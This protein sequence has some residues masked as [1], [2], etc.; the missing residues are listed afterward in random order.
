[1]ELAE[2]GLVVWSLGGLLR[3]LDFQLQDVAVESVLLDLDAV[4]LLVRRRELLV[5]HLL[6]LDVDRLPGYDNENRT[7][8]K[9]LSQWLRQQEKKLSSH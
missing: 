6:D 1:M 3:L 4:G 2:S 7:I 8:Q 9:K 5:K